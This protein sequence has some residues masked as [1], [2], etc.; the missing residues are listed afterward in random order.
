[1]SDHPDRE[2]VV[3]DASALVDLL[4]AAP[5]AGAIRER[6][7]GTLLHAPAHFDAEVLSALGRLHR[8]GDLS[9]SEVD[10]ALAH[11]SA[12]PVTRHPIADL[13]TG[14]WARRDGLRLVDAL[15]VELAARL[16][17]RLLTL[18]QRL[19]RACPIADAITAR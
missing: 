19:A 16:G 15:Y 8:S 12:M 3:L 1:M 6:L 17:A 18:D 7:R 5:S 9:V 2:R 11:L 13:L 4:I 14:A 10:Q